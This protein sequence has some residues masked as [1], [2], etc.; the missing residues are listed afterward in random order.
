MTFGFINSDNWKPI[1]GINN[2]LFSLETI[3]IEEDKN[4]VMLQSMQMCEQFRKMNISGD[5]W[6]CMDLEEEACP[7]VDK[8]SPV[9]LKR[10]WP[11]VKSQENLDKMGL[12]GG[13]AD[14]KDGEESNGG[15]LRDFK[16][17]RTNQNLELEEKGLLR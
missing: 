6:N 16:K 15:S 10:F 4:Y 1:Y 3:L 2:I 12:E 7:G 17:I 11:E 9:S 14:S 13:S 8:F 5:G